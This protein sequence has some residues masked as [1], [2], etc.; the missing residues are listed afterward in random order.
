M[1]IYQE[2]DFSFLFSLLIFILHRHGSEKAD[3]ELLI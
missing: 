1:R 2:S 3:L